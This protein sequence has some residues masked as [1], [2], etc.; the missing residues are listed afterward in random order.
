MAKMLTSLSFVSHC[1]LSSSIFLLASSRPIRISSSLVA[2][3]VVSPIVFVVVGSSKIPSVNTS[4]TTFETFDI[5]PLRVVKL[6]FTFILNHDIFTKSNFSSHSN[7]LHY[8]ID[9][10]QFD[11][12]VFVFANA[13]FS[14]FWPFIGNA[15]YC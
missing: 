13:K 9:N 3:V 11:S 15:I 7:Q 4:C 6:S 1:A 5:C 2:L 12:F 10:S 8:P 14:Q